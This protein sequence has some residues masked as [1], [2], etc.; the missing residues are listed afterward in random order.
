MSDPTRV[1]HRARAVGD[2]DYTGRLIDVLVT[3]A[4]RRWPDAT[5][6]FD[7]GSRHTFR[8]I[9]QLVDQ[10]ATRLRSLGVGPD[11]IVSW[12][13]PNWV[14]AIVVHH[15]I[16]RVGAVSNPIV[17]IYRD[18]EVSFILNQVGARVF[19]V[20][21]RF[22]GHDHTAL[23][24]RMRDRVATLE[25]VIVVPSKDGDGDGGGTVAAP[26]MANFGQEVGDGLITRTA[27]DLAVV[28]FTSGT[29]SNPKGV[30]HSHNTLNF[31][32]EST[33]EL[34]GITEQ[35]VVLMASPLSHIAGLL[36]GAQLPFMTG[37]Q[38]VLQDRW[39][40]L[41]A[42]EL[43]R[44]HGCTFTLSATPFLHGLVETGDRGGAG[45][46]SLRVFACGGAAVPPALAEAADAVIGGYVTRTYGLTEFPT[47]TS[48]GAGDGLHARTHTDGRACRGVSLRVV[49]DQGGVLPPGKVGELEVSGPEMFLG[50]LDP[51]ADAE[52]F[53]A[54]GWLRTGDLATI[55][56]DGYVQIT[57]RSKDL[58]VRG[59]EKISP[60][61]IEDLL[62][63]HPRVQEVAVVGVSDPVMV[64]RVCA[65]VVVRPGSRPPT[66][67]EIGEYL[68]SQ[69]VAKQKLPEYLF[70]LPRLPMTESGKVQKSVL[71]SQ[72]EQRSVEGVC[73]T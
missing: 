66:L 57:G 69:G 5:A 19:I 65:F 71:R 16:L 40:A 51:E 14:E 18:R 31:E 56:A 47:V 58:I 70:S 7:R 6:V 63:T 4:A 67:A 49:D 23:A 55:D 30:M 28:L 2:A 13:L 27:D 10:C 42:Q 34:F 39:D 8:E 36:Y 61:E 11:E 24:E 32:N 38:V 20:P 68:E 1:R 59:G 43:I 50:Y 37:A 29:T 45:H 3:D 25:H 72:A 44:D 22:R 35:D 15:A 21:D 53:T 9:D 33:T 12:Q 60:L 26:P 46:Q 64:E 48:C 73:L 62:R 54:D 17:P 52:A 41:A